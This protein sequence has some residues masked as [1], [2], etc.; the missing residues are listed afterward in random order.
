MRLPRAIARGPGTFKRSR[1]RELAARARHGV[2]PPQA[3]NRGAV[4]RHPGRRLASLATR[5]P[6]AGLSTTTANIQS[7][8]R[9]GRMLSVR[10]PAPLRPSRATRGAQRSP[11]APQA[12]E[13]GGRHPGEAWPVRS[14]T[15][16]GARGVTRADRA[17]ASSDREGRQALTARAV[18]Q[19]H[20]PL[21]R[22]QKDRD[23]AGPPGKLGRGPTA[24]HTRALP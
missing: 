23:T 17:R 5:G 9:R 11:G 18:A 22:E 13:A 4:P 6:L 14:Q 16:K 1:H 8:S 21:S 20:R 12:M 2:S 7:R 3:S 10:V 24:T 15:G 19:G